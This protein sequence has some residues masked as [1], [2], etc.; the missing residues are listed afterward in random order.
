MTLTR[1]GD[2]LAALALGGVLALTTRAG[3]EWLMITAI[4]GFAPFLMIAAF[5]GV[6]LAVLAV[7][8]WAVFRVTGGMSTILGF[9]AALL[10][11]A[12]VAVG[13]PAAERLRHT[14]EIA[15][16][17]TG[18][19]GPVR[20]VPAQARVMLAEY[21]DGQVFG[22]GV[23]CREE[24]RSLLTEGLVDEV[25]L[26]AP[27]GAAPAGMSVRLDTATEG[28]GT[29][30]ACLDIRPAAPGPP[31]ALVIQRSLDTGPPETA[32]LTGAD[33]PDIHGVQRVTI[34]FEGQPILRRTS[35][36]VHTL[37][38]V[39]LPVATRGAMGER[40]AIGYDRRRFWLSPHAPG[41][42]SRLTRLLSAV[43][44]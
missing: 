28:C 4:S 16:L 6:G 29:L 32:L 17:F 13:Y 12:V 22:R 33:G 43:M 14:N 37:P 31:P 35:G 40:L 21:R 20:R 25:R 8:G 26:A 42:H 18:D 1:I 24:C 11:V 30:G 9:G 39:A 27:F 10:A 36:A 41:G 15:P 3:S 38:P 19:F 7:L 44:E 23:Q 34:Y 2:I 5:L